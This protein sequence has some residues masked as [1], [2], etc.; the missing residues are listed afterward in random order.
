MEFM[1]KL[2]ANLSQS[3]LCM[4]VSYEEKSKNK[5]FTCQVLQI[6]VGLSLFLSCCL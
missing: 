4:Y 5:K 1:P 3:V 2:V 6:W